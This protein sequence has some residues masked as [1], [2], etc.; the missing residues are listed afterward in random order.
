M[1]LVFPNQ[2]DADGNPV[3]FKVAFA[4]PS[5][6]IRKRLRAAELAE[7]Q[8]LTKQAEADP[9]LLELMADLSKDGIQKRIDAINKN[10]ALAVKMEQWRNQQN[11]L[12]ETKVLTQLRAI[13]SLGGLTEDQRVLIQSD[14]DSE[15]WQSQSI[16]TAELAVL[17]FSG[18]LPTAGRPEDPRN[19]GVASIPSTPSAA[20]VVA[21]DA[22]SITQSDTVEPPASAGE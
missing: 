9:E 17:T 21:A 14:I 18:K 7:T 15:F 5:A 4:W 16:P 22:T 1:K 10:P 13:C 20:T 3:T 2:F 19:S 11:D 12:R 8:A 6:T